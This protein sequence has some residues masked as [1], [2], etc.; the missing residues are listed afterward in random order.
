MSDKEKLYAIRKTNTD[1]FSKEKY[2]YWSWADYAEDVIHDTSYFWAPYKEFIKLVYT[3]NCNNDEHPFLFK[4]SSDARHFIDE[5]NK[6]SLEKFGEIVFD[7][8]NIE[9]V[10][11]DFNSEKDCHQV[12]FGNDYLVRINNTIEHLKN[13]YYSKERY[14]QINLEGNYSFIVGQALQ[15]LVD[16]ANLGSDNMFKTFNG[17]A[18]ECNRSIESIE[19]VLK[20]LN[21]ISEDVNKAI[22]NVKDIKKHELSNTNKETNLFN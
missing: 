13:D 17:K 7:L 22:A 2:A 19:N 21:S 4:N 12:V 3:D 15:A 10:E 14:V 6:D 8:F 16:I 9:V 1:S 20:T 5:H 18:Y 11:V